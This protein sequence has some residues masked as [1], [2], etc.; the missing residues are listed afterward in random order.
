[1]CFGGHDHSYITFLNKETNVYLVK[2]GCDFEEFS[3][4]TVLFGVEQDDAEEFIKRE[5]SDI[6]KIDYSK[7]LKR[8]FICEKVIIT[9]DRFVADPKIIEHIFKYTEELNK[10]LELQAGYSS[11]DLEARFSRVRTEETNLGNWMADLIRSEM[12]A[13]FGISNGGSLRAN[14][15]FKQGRI[16]F[17]FI[18]DILPMTD[19]ICSFRITGKKLKEILECGLSMY[20]KLDG[21]FPLTSGIK[22]KFDPELEIGNRIL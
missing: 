13:D 1:M 11:V 5:L 21:R 12:Q 14:C 16:N 10:K 6:V 8:L 17:K 4:I 20:P 9:N 22:F 18:S 3:N 7:N 2:S 15:I 19:L